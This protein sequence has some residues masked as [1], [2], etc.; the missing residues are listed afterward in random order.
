MSHPNF[1]RRCALT[2]SYSG[3]RTRFRAVLPAAES[4][5]AHNFGILP[6]GTES[7][8]LAC[9]SNQYEKPASWWRGNDV[10]FEY[11]RPVGSRYGTISLSSYELFV[12]LCGRGCGSSCTASVSSDECQSWEAKVS[13]RLARELRREIDNPGADLSIKQGHGACQSAIEGHFPG[14]RYGYA[15]RYPMLHFAPACAS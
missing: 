1:S 11:S 3:S 4:A 14:S 2:G 9:S 13:I 7:H 12:R 10:K 5:R 8:G 15:D 6:C